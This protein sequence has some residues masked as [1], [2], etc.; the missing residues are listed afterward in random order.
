[1][2][3]NQDGGAET[4]MGAAAD[5]VRQKPSGDDESQSTRPD[6]VSEGER[7]DQARSLMAMTLRE[8]EVIARNLK[9]SGTRR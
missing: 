4:A 1:M 2:S 9:E 8:A 7:S 5:P 3:S 6:P